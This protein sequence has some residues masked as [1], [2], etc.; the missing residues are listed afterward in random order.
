MPITNHVPPSVERRDHRRRT[1]VV[2]LLLGIAAAAASLMSTEVRATADE[3]APTK[4][5]AN[6]PNSPAL[7][8]LASAD[9]P[10]LL[11]EPQ[12]RDAADASVQFRREAPEGEPRR[13]PRGRVEDRPASVPSDRGANANS[14]EVAAI[15]VTAA[16]YRDAVA[17]GDVEAVAKFWTPDADYVDQAGHA[18][19]IKEKL[20]EA[21]AKQRQGQPAGGRAVA[22]PGHTIRIITPGVAIQDGSFQHAADA[23]GEPIAGHYTAVWL[24]RDGH[25]LLDGVRESAVI[26]ATP[27]DHLKGLS[28]LVGE[29]EGKG[30]GMTADASYVWGPDKNYLLRKVVLRGSKGEIDSTIQWIGWD[31]IQ[32]QIRSFVFD[33]GGGFED[34]V[35]EKE[36]DAWVATAHGVLPDG[37]RAYFTTIHSRVDAN[38]IICEIV[39]DEIDGEPIEDVR[40]DFKRKVKT[41][42]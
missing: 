28:W 1:V 12:H 7:S 20:N 13:R 33:S 22:E 10:S 9:D 19:P 6:E 34:G 8:Q 16:A 26:N 41:A 32:K 38:N 25:W 29:W 35:W 23:D 17:K 39:D 3:A 4:N 30:S 5:Q 42:Q 11:P 40:I 14:A 21:R 2:L 27:A 18:F 31:P 24:K 15:E 36:G 37:R